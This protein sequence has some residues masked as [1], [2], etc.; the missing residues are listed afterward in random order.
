[1]CI[2]KYK[3]IVPE[4]GKNRRKKGWKTVLQIIFVVLLFPLVYDIIYILAVVRWCPTRFT[5]DSGFLFL[6]SYLPAALLRS[7][8]LYNSLVI[9]HQD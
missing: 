8:T 6:G 2:I 4:T 1:M 9:C 3:N 5:G 7:V